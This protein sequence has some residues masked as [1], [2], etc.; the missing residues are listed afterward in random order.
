[1][2]I[3]E[4]RTSLGF[5]Q[6]VSDEKGVIRI[7]WLQDGL[8]TEKL[9]TSYG[10]EKM[11]IETIKEYFS[12]KTVDFENIPL[13]LEGT[14]FELKVWEV[15][16]I[17]PYGERKTYSDIAN[18]IDKKNA[19]R[20]VGNACGKNPVP[21]LIPCHRVIKTDGSLGGYSSGIARKKKLLE[22]EN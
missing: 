13:N 7:T 11:L 22:L 14:D 19:Q 6:I 4:I 15:L 5:L 18:I 20:A 3:I 21:L 10:F 1:M 9:D 8:K 16:R 17:I 12:G 2:N